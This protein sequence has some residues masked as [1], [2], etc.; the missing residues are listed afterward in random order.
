MTRSL[1]L[2]GG[3]ADRAIDCPRGLATAPD[4]VEWSAGTS[5]TIYVRSHTEGLVTVYRPD[6]LIDRIVPAPKRRAK[7]AKPS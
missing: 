4:T 6:R 5:T 1:L 7:R 3:A 2:R